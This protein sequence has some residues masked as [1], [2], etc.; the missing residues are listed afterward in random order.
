MKSRPSR[1]VLLATAALSF[2]LLAAE[3][4]RPPAPPALRAEDPLATELGRVRVEQELMLAE[5]TA[6][7]LDAFQ[8]AL[9]DWE[10]ERTTE[11]GAR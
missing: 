7:M 5:R 9:E 1:P 11:D 6:A 2:G 4:G 10:H 8:Q 3:P